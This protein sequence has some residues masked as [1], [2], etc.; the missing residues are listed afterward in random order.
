MASTD[1]QELAFYP[2]ID[3]LDVDAAPRLWNIN[4]VHMD[5]KQTTIIGWCL[6]HEG[7]LHQL[8][9]KVNG[10]LHAM[11]HEA[12]GAAYPLL[13]PWFPN[14]AW[15]GYKLVIPHAKQDLRKAEEISMEPIP[16]SGATSA[17]YYTLNV[18]V[19]DL[20]FQMPPTDIAARIGATNQMDYVTLG[21]S[22]FRGFERALNKN[23]GTSFKDYDTILDW[24]CGSGR[25]AR[26]TVKAIGPQTTFVGYDIDSYAVDW[27]NKNI[28]GFFKV[29]STQ[30]P[31]GMPDKSVD[32]LYAYSV[33]TH[34]S[35]ENL[36]IWTEE[37]Y[38]MLRPG[39]VALV[40]V[41]SDRAM[42]SLFP[43]MPRDS[44]INWN[45]GGVYDS[46][47]NAQ[48]DTLEVSKDYYRN[49]WLKRAYM[50]RLIA[51]KFEMV[52]YIGSFHFYQDLM[53]L[54]RL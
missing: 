11:A 16:V 51:G 19:S 15:A 33:F 34:L 21:R 6:P 44:L 31:V 42:I 49:V 40:T 53:V 50:D 22:I 24:G 9:M 26:H 52:D 12:P 4:A 41:L 23:F 14:A 27:S 38:R 29:C 17:P 30:P 48:L 45:K 43:D 54:R 28:G 36:K 46:L 13:Y 35:D 8:Q 37:L 2:N 32:V 10:V 47:L 5:D 20:S 7:R 18:L 3:L 25:V 39:G 1:K